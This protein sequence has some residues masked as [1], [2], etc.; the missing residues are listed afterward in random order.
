M[1]RVEKLRQFLIKNGY[2]KMQTFNTRNIV[3]DLMR[4]I[5]DCD[6][7]SVD[8]CDGWQYLEIFG[9]RDEEYE[10]LR[11]TLDIERIYSCSSY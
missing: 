2:S 8:I 1:N 5:Y 4:N 11:D 7:I 10:S 3:G 9:L 6:G